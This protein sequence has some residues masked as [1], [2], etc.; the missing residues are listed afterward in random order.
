MYIFLP[1][2]FLLLFPFAL[3][4]SSLNL[5][6]VLFSEADAK[7]PCFTPEEVALITARMMMQDLLPSQSELSS[8]IEDNEYVN[9]V[10]EYFRLILDVVRCHSSGLGKHILLLALT[11]TLGGY[12]NSIL[13]PS[14]KYAYYAGLLNYNNIVKMFHLFDEMKLFLRTSGVGWAGP[15]HGAGNFTNSS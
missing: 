7:R 14:A 10:V 3:S 1:L 2:S 15:S 5:G 9:D 4:S 8:K 11:D 12:M 6:T 13:I